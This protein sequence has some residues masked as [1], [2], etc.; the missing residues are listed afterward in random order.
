MK[1][2][3]RFEDFEIWKDG[4]QVTKTLLV[5]SNELEDRKLVSKHF[6]KIYF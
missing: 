3:F 4:I 6:K 5:I 2:V 1:A